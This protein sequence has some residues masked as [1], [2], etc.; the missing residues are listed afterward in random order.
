LPDYRF[1][2]NRREDLKLLQ[3]FRDFRLSLSIFRSLDRVQV[4]SEVRIVI[5]AIDHH[6]HD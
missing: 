5:G 3:A 1:H 6:G 2:D 4:D